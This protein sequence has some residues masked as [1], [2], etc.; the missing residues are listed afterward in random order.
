[1]IRYI[2]T[3]VIVLATSTQALAI[4][5]SVD[6]GAT[7]KKS[8][9]KSVQKKQSQ[10][11][12]RSTEVTLS[13]DALFKPVLLQL[14][15]EV[16]PWSTC[17]VMSNPML[18]ADIRLAAVDKDGFIDTVRAEII[19]QAAAANMDISAVG[20]DERRLQDWIQ[21]L[22]LYGSVIGQAY[23][24]LQTSLPK[25]VKIGRGKDAVVIS[26]LDQESMVVMSKIETDKVLASSVKNKRIRRLYHQILENKSPCRFGNSKEQLVC[27]PVSVVLAPRTKM[28]ISGVEFFGD[29]FA[30]YA[31]TIKLHAGSNES[32][33]KVMAI[34]RSWDKDQ[35]QRQHV[36]LSR[37][38]PGVHE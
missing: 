36:S 7:R 33:D 1:M 31:G 10:E 34:R 32:K 23:S 20:A 9:D 19:N 15:Q 14:E 37:L 6:S 27:G 4:D 30:G 2:L 35:S 13:L 22:A 29:Q 28:F 25:V 26:G 3:L 8:R 24:N 5:T 16:P 38:I 18:P 11:H 12:G 21:C 17:R